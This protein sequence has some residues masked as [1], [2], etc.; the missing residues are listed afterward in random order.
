MPRCIASLST[1]ISPL[2]PWQQPLGADLSRWKNGRSTTLRTGMS[3]SAT[4]HPR[5]QLMLDPSHMIKLV[6]NAFGDLRVLRNGKGEEINWKFIENL[7]NLQ[8]ACEFRAG[9]RLTHKH[10]NWKKYIMR[11]HI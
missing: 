4:G 2:F 3:Q 5:I 7:M 10:L 11:V 6:R 8:L 9:N 1:A